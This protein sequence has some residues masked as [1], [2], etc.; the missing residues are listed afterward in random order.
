MCIKRSKRH[1]CLQGTLVFLLVLCFLLFGTIL[2]MHLV[3]YFLTEESTSFLERQQRQ[4]SNLQDDNLMW[5]S[6]LQR[7]SRQSEPLPFSDQLVE[8]FFVRDCPFNQWIIQS[9]MFFDLCPEHTSIES[10]NNYQFNKCLRK[11]F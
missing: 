8:F 6:R 1:G 4:V 9:A 11:F 3:V 5:N 10:M 2:V 7:Q